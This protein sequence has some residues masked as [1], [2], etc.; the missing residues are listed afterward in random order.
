MVDEP[1]LGVAFFIPSTRKSAF[2]APRIRT[3]DDRCFTMFMSEPACE[4]SLG[5]TN[6]SDGKVDTLLYEIKRI[7]MTLNEINE[8]HVK[9]SEIR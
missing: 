2:L 7:K 5:L 9:Y 1:C 4:T 8:N 6:M 3:V